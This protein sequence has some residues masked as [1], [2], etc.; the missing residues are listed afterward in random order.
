MEEEGKPYKHYVVLINMINVRDSGMEYNGR[1][2]DYNR[3]DGRR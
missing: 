3:T 1:T 2:N